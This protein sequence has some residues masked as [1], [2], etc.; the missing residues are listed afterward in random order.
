MGKILHP[1]LPHVCFAPRNNNL[2]GSRLLFIFV[3]VSA[4]GPP[5]PFMCMWSSTNAVKRC[6]IICKTRE[7]RYRQA[8]SYVAATSL[9]LS[10]SLTHTHTHSLIIS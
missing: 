6:Q 8:F 3:V 10:L 2:L 1:P 9:S 7:L 5:K 4:G